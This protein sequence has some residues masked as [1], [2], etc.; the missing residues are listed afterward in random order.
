MDNCEQRILFRIPTM[1]KEIAAIACQEK[2]EQVNDSKTSNLPYH[3]SICE[4]EHTI[5]KSENNKYD[6]SGGAP[7]KKN[8]FKQGQI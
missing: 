8:N 7:N 6:K 4:A 5:K 1:T 3:I 2:N